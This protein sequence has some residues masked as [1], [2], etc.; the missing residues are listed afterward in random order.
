MAAEQSA[1]DQCRA[2]DRIDHLLVIPSWWKDMTGDDW[3][4]NGVSRNRFRDYLSD[5]LWQES[6]QVIERVQQGCIR[7]GIKYRSLV[8]LGRS[9][10]MLEETLNQNEYDQIF[11]GSRRP[12]HQLGLRDTMLTTKIIKQFIKQLYIVA[13]PHA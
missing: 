12:K 9:D 8:H 4:N 2:G 3:L 1:I 6:Q 10:R 13:H 11:M 5:Q 7:N